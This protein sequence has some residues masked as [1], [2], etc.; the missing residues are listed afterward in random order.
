MKRFAITLALVVTTAHAEFKDGN[1]LLSELRG[2][3]MERIHAMGYIMGV[4]DAGR[5]VTVCPPD[6]ITAGQLTDMVQQHLDAIPSVRHLTA[7]T[8]VNY[9]LSQAWPC[10]KRS[11][12]GGNGV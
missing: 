9:V 4:F 11:N 5:G 8:H 10:A 7:D 2:Q 1:K 12:R 6:G 3:A